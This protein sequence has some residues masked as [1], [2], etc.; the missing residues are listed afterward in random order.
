MPT[1]TNPRRGLPRSRWERALGL[2]DQIVTWFKPKKPPGWMTPEQFASLPNEITVR[3]LRYRVETRGFRTREITLVTTLLDAQIYSAA[4]IADLY[5][6]RWQT[7]LDLRSIKDVLQMDVLRCK[8]PE[9]V[10]NGTEQQNSAILEHL[11]SASYERL[12]SDAFRKI[13]SLRAV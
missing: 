8:T 1:A 5:Y 11:A 3:E 10:V 9:M 7:E 6:R 12:D 13:D 4:A 2:N